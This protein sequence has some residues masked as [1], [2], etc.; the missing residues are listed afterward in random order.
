V[1]LVYI[2]DDKSRE[3]K[4]LRACQEG[5]AVGAEEAIK[6]GANLNWQENVWKSSFLHIAVSSSAEIVRLLLRYQINC[7]LLDH[8]DLTP[9]MRACDSS[10]RC[11]LESIEALIEYGA[12]VNA[13]REGDQMSPLKFAVGRWP[14]EVARF[15]IDK[16]ASVEGTRPGFTPLM[17]AARSNNASA[18]KVLLEA[19]ANPEAKCELNWANGATAEGIAKLEGRRKALK[20]FTTFRKQ[21][22]GIS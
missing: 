15:L 14:G 17:L 5:D 11:A 21:Q 16:G 19:G 18:I 1:D 3:G 12:N 2:V 20:A 4:L 22:A 6:L 9:L 7:E 13:S 8:N 10:N